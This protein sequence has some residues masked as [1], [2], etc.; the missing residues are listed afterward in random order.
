MGDG[1]HG[2]G[3]DFRGFWGGFSEFGEMEPVAFRFR[4]FGRRSVASAKA[5]VHNH[6]RI[7]AFA[8]MTKYSERMNRNAAD[9]SR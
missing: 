4:W 6:Y 1:K 8:G 7:P 2:F 9:G 5:G 3:G